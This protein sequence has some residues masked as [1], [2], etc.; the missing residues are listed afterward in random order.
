MR[1][2]NLCACAAIL[3]LSSSASAYE[4]RCRFV[5]Q[6]GTGVSAFSVLPGNQIDISTGLPRRIRIQ[7]GVF[8]DAVSPAP[9]G[10]FIGWNM[11]SIVVSG[12]AGNSV[13]RRTPGRLNVFAFPSGPNAN[14]NP[15]LPDGDP[16]EMLT[17]IDATMGPQTR[18]W[19]C[20]PDG[21][22]PPMPEPIVRARNTFISVF[23]FTI[24]PIEFQNY[25]VTVT[26]NAVASAGWQTVG[27]PVPPDCG[28]P[29]NPN[30][31][32]P[33]SVVYE[34]AAEAG[35]GIECVLFCLVPGPGTG[36]VLAVM[37]AMVL[38]RRR[39]M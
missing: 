2:L 17:E 33:G 10:G 8:D 3:G 16:F 38:R 37:G 25:T 23:E 11:G 35:R 22:V 1:R 13:E 19:V 12:P 5:E 7:F 27:T 6:T 34:A 30:D 9:E 15:P 20:N 14:G 32:V 21:S 29:M 28:D 24:D 36:S 39:G 26:G 31:D 4:L 18:P